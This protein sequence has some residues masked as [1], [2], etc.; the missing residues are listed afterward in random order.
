MQQCHLQEVWL[1][2]L[3]ETSKGKKVN[4][5]AANIHIASQNKSGEQRSAPNLQRILIK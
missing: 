2:S 3:K 4:D 5:E 1:C